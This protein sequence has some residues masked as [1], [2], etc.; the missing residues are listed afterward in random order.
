MD[1]KKVLVIGSGPIII[2]QSCEFDYSGTQACKALKQLGYYIVLLN[3]NPATI[4]T[5]P[6]MADA[7]YM[8]DMTLDNVKKII[9]KE[10][11]NFVL[12]IVGGQ[13]G[14][15][16]AKDLDTK[17]LSI[18]VLGSNIKTIELCEN[19]QEFKKAMDE[20][21]IQTTKSYTLSDEI[22]YP[23][24]VRPSYELGGSNAAICN[25]KTELLEVTSKFKDYIIEQSIYG[26]QE[27]EIEIIR[28]SF[29]NK[30]I[31][32]TIENIDPVGIHTGDSV[33]VSPFITV[34]KELQNKIE[35]YS[36]QI[37]EKLNVIGGCNIQFAY[38]N[39]TKELVIIEVN[40]RTSRSSALASKATGFPIAYIAT[41]LAM[42]QEMPLE[43]K[44][45]KQGNGYF[46]VK[47]PR[48]DMKK[49]DPKDDCLG[50]TMKATGEVLSF[51]KSF[52]EAYK[53][54]LDSLEQDTSIDNCTLKDIEKFTSKTH[55]QILKLLEMGVS[56]DDISNTTKIHPWFINQ[57]KNISKVTTDVKYWYKV[58]VV[59]NKERFYYYSTF[60][61]DNN[62]KEISTKQ[63]VI[64]IGSGPNR[65]G[66]GIEFDYC[67]I[68]AA[69]ALQKLGYEVIMLNSNPETV[70]TDYDIADRLYFEPVTAESVKAIYDKEQ[71][72]GVL[73]QFGGQTALNIA[74][75]LK[76]SNVKF[77]D[78]D[79]DTIDTIENRYKFSDFIRKCELL[80]PVG[81]YLDNF[82]AAKEYIKDLNYPVIARPSYVI[83]GSGI[84]IINNETELK[85][86][87]KDIKG[88]YI[89]QFL[90]DRLEYEVDI[91]VNGIDFYYLNI[92]NEQE[93]TGV[94][95]G[96]SVEWLDN[97]LDDLKLR[98]NL[99][100]SKIISNLNYKGIMNIQFTIDNGQIVVLE[101]NPRCS[102]T[103]PFISKVYGFDMIQKA[104]EIIMLNKCTVE[105]DINKLKYKAIKQPVFSWNKF[106][107]SSK[108]LLPIMHSTGEKISLV[109]ENNIEIVESIQNLIK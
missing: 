66:Q 79:F 36:K 105:G 52:I 108:E 17:E 72:I 93:L 94:H 18:E 7:T 60:L 106:L 35:E 3:N 39:K 30:T 28:D 75:A 103:V 20:I 9:K 1:K 63:K 76:D 90:K 40:P 95:S 4:M 15:N 57:L 92:F 43:V 101:I 61:I 73:A 55:F 14:L 89:D 27:L 68:H 37:V 88:T 29:N 104:I 24:I 59:L 2:G 87:F 12:P 85:E 16:L 83:G 67:C 80:T 71:P 10:K 49:F 84:K 91:I 74:L 44:N 45:W 82:E 102:R 34:S 78:I 100:I 19:R 11:V 54:A 31:V 109:N 65:I 69:K 96:D 99:V 64:V 21:C 25:N 41:C 70:S 56:I 23:V 33:C 50:L 107:N 38:N 51:G 62:E 46:A 53:K 5:D 58:P 47:F 22:K 97:S 8:C 77:L 42:G 13:T 26:W 81:T 86:L 6:M 98:L 48:F 32:C